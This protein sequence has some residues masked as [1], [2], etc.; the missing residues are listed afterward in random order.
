MAWAVLV[1]EC[2]YLAVPRVQISY[3]S[4]LFF[5]LLTSAFGAEADKILIMKNYVFI[6][7]WILL[8]LLQSCSKED[9]EPDP[10][11][12][13]TLS[14]YNADLNEVI[15]TTN[16][17]VNAYSY[18]WDD[19]QG[20]KSTLKEP[21]IYYDQPGQYVITLTAYS[22]SG[23]KQSVANS[24]VIVEH[25]TGQVS[26]WQSGTPSY[27]IT[28]VV[29]N[30]I[31]RYITSDYPDGIPDC[32]RDGCANFTLPSGT[33]NFHAS[34]GTYQ[35]NGSVTITGDGCTKFQLQ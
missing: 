6:I 1:C 21:S 24:S 11:A 14:T 17:S 33:Y 29:I 8:L 35:W 4:T 28:E 27:G 5:S 34:D 31:S 20:N 2:R 19:G 30:N 25:K 22:S 7:S 32:D 9:P 15:S 16:C 13:F 12:C 3:S 26:F 23:S 18:L 10:F